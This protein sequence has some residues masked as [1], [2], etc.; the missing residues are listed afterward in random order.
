ME[1]T[2]FERERLVA[3]YA[4]ELNNTRYRAS[5][6]EQHVVAASRRAED[7]EHRFTDVLSSTSWRTTLPLRVARRPRTYLKRLLHR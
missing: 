1:Q 2:A 4:A 7:A 6:S 5:V 3:W